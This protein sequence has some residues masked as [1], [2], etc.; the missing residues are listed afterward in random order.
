MNSC[1]LAHSFE[2]SINLLPDHFQPFLSDISPND[3]PWDIHKHQAVSVSSILST[4]APGHKKLSERMLECAHQLEFGWTVPDISTDKP[5]LKLKN[6]RFC[7]VRICPVCQWRR[8]LMWVSRFYNAFPNIYRDHP[9]WRYI[10]LTL[11]VK[12]CSI[13]DLKDTI[14]DM[15]L[16]FQRL[17]QRKTWPAHGFLRSLEVT[18]SKDGSAHPH[19]HL[20]LAVSPS[21]FGRKYISTSKWADLWK[22]CLRIDYT[23][24]CD[25]RIVKPKDDSEWIG[26]TVWKDDPKRELFE[27]GVDSVEFPMRDVMPGRTYGDPAMNVKPYEFIFSAIK[28]VIKYTVKPSDMISQPSWLLELVSQL[29]KSRAVSVGGEFKAYLR[30][31][32]I[33]TDQDLVCESE[34]IKEN[35]GGVYFGWRENVN[36][37][38]KQVKA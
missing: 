26:K 37:Y 16:G 35:E 32:D 7:R 1:V 12:N 31:D 17:I 34:T 27:I 21:Y 20:L 6:S 25:V 22:S 13:Y 2:Q 11:T 15:N 28:E 3:K 18:R 8:S 5:S 30:D 9:E 19:F 33:E 4:G 24:I 29:H 38:Q 10:F 23:P 36:R 14:N